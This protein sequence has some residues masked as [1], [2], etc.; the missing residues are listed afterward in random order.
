M[1]LNDSSNCFLLRK[2]LDIDCKFMDYYLGVFSHGHLMRKPLYTDY[3][4]MVFT[5]M[6]SQMFIQTA[7]YWKSLRTLDAN[8]WFL[9]G[10]CFQMFFFQI[11]IQWECLWTVLQKYVFWPWCVLKW[12][13]KFLSSQKYFW[14]WLQG[15]GFSPL[16]IL[17]C[18]FYNPHLVRKL[19][20]NKCKYMDSHLCV[21]SNVFFKSLSYEKA[22]W[23]WLQEHCFSPVCILKQFLNDFFHIPNILDTILY[24]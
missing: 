1:F 20:Y 22:F 16:C 18:F 6:C 13:F 12:F 7:I 4:D 24:L 14:H 23:H 19:L 21:F 3:K 17:K 5:N 2:I 8:V 9:T 11:H 15:H 10:V